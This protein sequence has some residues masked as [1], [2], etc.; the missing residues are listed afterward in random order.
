MSI[1]DLLIISK[2]GQSHW[3]IRNDQEIGFAYY[4]RKRHGR[5]RWCTIYF[6]RRMFRAAS[7]KRKTVKKKVEKPVVP[8]EPGKEKEK[9]VAVRPCS[10]PN[11][12]E[13]RFE[14]RPDQHCHGIH[15]T[16]RRRPMI[17]YVRWWIA[18][19]S[20]G[21][22]MQKRARK[23]LSLSFGFRNLSYL[24]CT[25]TVLIMISITTS[26]MRLKSAPVSAEREH[27]HCVQ[28]GGQLLITLIGRWIGS[29]GKLYGKWKWLR[30]RELSRA[31]YRRNNIDS[32]R[33][34]SK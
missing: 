5:T 13:Q 31:T 8:L 14:N 34:Q 32:D 20:V 27:V 1:W 29:L 3:Y 2:N 22:Y 9:C 23:I 10:L 16:R 11:G 6:G 33:R 24:H 12:N 4:A 18:R 21:D 26:G 15:L 25:P 30:H 17:A 19:N 28:C 7:K